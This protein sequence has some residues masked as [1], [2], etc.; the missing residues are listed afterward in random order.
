MF[1]SK[2][3]NEIAA[4]DIAAKYGNKEILEELWVWGRKVQVNIKNDLFLAKDRIKKLPGQSRRKWLQRD[5]RN[6]VGVRGEKF[7]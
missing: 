2:A 1:A 4:W 5:F 7:K 6:A 3:M